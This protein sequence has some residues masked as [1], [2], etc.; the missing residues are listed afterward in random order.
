MR[1]RGALSHRTA[2]DLHGLRPSASAR[3]EL[4]GPTQRHRRRGLLIHRAPVPRGQVTKIDGLP[5][6]TA[7]RTLLDL[8]DILSLDALRRCFEAAD[9]LRLLD[10]RA[11]EAVLATADGR[12]G[13][14]RLAGLLSH[15]LDGLHCT[16]SDFERD[17]LA[18]CSTYG[19]S[20][21]KVNQAVEGFEVDICWP[22]QRLVIELDSVFFHATRAAMNRD[23]RRDLVPRLAG[24]EPVRLTYQQVVREAPATAAALR[25]LL[26][27]SG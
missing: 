19:L 6:T 20:T 2:A 23:R 9:R 18:L 5:V 21:P 25:T 11:V 17:F 15:H 26:A 12:R 7:P 3:V 1:P 14:A 13:V 4:T 27:R 16:R 24:R 8:A 10:I 22:E